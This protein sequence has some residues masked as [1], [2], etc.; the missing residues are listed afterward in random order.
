LLRAFVK[1]AHDIPLTFA[2]GAWAGSPELFQGDEIFGAI[3]PFDSQFLAD[4]LYVNGSH[5][6][7]PGAI[8]WHYSIPLRGIE[9]KAFAR[10]FPRRRALVGRGSCRALITYSTSGLFIENGFS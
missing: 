3:L 6:N 4:G 8:A 2:P 5:A 7:Y 10:P 1:I 9:E